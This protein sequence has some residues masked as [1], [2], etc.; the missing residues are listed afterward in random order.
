MTYEFD[1]HIHVEPVAD[2]EYE[3]DLAAG[4]VVGGGVNGGYL[5]AVIGNAFRAPCRR[6]RTRSRSAP[7]TS[8]PRAP[9]R[10]RSPPGSC[11][12]AAASPPSPRTWARTVSPGS[13]RWRRTATSASPTTWHDRRRAG[14]AA[15]GR[16]RPEHPGA[17]GGPQA[18][19]AA[20]PVRHALRPRLLGWAVGEPSGNG[21]IQGW[22]RLVDGRDDR[23]RC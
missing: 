10:R 11:A 18:G 8:P 7:T 1:E 4:W 15:A 2:G 16:V 23:S 20:G 12:K 19:A 9:A 6:S 3:A 5:L 17:A 21:M 14:A 22:F 13:P